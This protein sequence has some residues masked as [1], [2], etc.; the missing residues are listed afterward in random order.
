MLSISD[1]EV[2]DEHENAASESGDM[3][4]GYLDDAEE[5]EWNSSDDEGEE[6]ANMIGMPELHP[7]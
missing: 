2:A 7:V 3:V 1:S 6:E 5:D 4:S